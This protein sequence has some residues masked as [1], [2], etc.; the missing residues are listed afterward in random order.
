MIVNKF[1]N[2]DNCIF[3]S[4]KMRDIVTSVYNEDLINKGVGKYYIKGFESEDAFYMI[5]DYNTSEE[6]KLKPELHKVFTDI[7]F[8]VKGREK[9]GWKVISSGKVNSL[10]NKY[11]Y[12]EKKDICFLDVNNIS[13]NYFKMEI[14]EFYIFPPNTIHFPNL[15][16]KTVSN[17][18]KV[19]IK[20]RT[21]FLIY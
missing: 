13:L 21:D 2:L 11:G 16:N 15:N 9:C 6:S 7:Q 10:C 20:I 8:I 4:K 1:N 3:L 5:M 19:V 12:N 17:V 14:G 18:R